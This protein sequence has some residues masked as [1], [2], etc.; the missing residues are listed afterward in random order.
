[1]TIKQNSGAVKPETAQEAKA[2]EMGAPVQYAGVLSRLI[3][4]A[5]RIKKLLEVPQRLLQPLFGWLINKSDKKS[6]DS[7]LLDFAAEADYAI[8]SQEPVRARALLRALVWIAIL[9]LVWASFA[10]VDEVTRG[11]GKVIPYSQIQVLQSMDGGVVAE[12]LVHEGDVV[13]KDQVLIRIDQTRFLSS[14]KENRAL[15]LSLSAKAARLRAIAEGSTF[16]PP[17]EVVRED[18]KIMEEERRL[19][20]ARK[21]E[22]D[23]T[24]SMTRQQMVQRQ[25]ELVELKAKLEQASRAYE[26]TNKELSATK[27]L[28]AAGA[29][30]DVEILRLERDVAR[31]RGEREMAAAQISRVTSAV[32]E[33]TRK[34]QEVEIAFRNEAR[35]ELNETLGKLNSMTEGSVGLSD[36]VA[37]SILRSPVKGIVKRLMVNTVGGVVQPGKDVIEIVPMEDNLFV[38]ARV[39]PKDIA[40]LR[41]GLKAT[42]K[43]SAYDFVIYGGLEGTLETIGADTVMDEKGN[44][45]YTVKVKT[46]KSTLGKDMPIM[47]GMVVEVDILTGEKSVLS[48]LLKPVLR[49]KSRALSER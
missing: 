25:Q 43:V 26:L 12:L 18:P 15:Y 3:S 29:V 2:G 28:V 40:F 35:K 8:L 48:Y 38:E 21:A 42:V 45:F 36:K 37:R 9:F 6:D 33:I 23:G 34:V 27:P 13:Q 41:P 30:S 1:M 46:T 39:Q 14:V 49:A 4:A 24:V 20:E 44:A 17:E 10:N 16:M 32:T 31:F 19:Y 5:G 22:L 7:Q 11:E 47:P